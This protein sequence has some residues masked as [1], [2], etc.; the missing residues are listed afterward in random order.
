M[1]IWNIRKFSLVFN[2]IIKVALAS[3]TYQSVLV[4]QTLVVTIA[5]RQSRRFVIQ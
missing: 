2:I 5:S 3:A 1:D 4:L